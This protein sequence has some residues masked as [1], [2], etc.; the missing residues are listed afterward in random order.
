MEFGCRRSAI[1]TGKLEASSPACE[2]QALRRASR[3]HRIRLA[4]LSGFCLEIFA[5]FD[6]NAARISLDHASI[7]HFPGAC[8]QVGLFF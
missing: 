7:L 3:H 6:I 5:S 2:T 8:A 1:A 4:G